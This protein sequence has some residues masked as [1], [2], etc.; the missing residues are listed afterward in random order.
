MSMSMTG[1][2]SVAAVV[3]EAVAVAVPFAFGGVSIPVFE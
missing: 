3:V 1:Q 2:V